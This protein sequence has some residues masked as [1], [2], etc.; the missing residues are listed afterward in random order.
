MKTID[1]GTL[2]VNPRLLP[3]QNMNSAT[4]VSMIISGLRTNDRGSLKSGKSPSEIA[5]E[6]SPLLMELSGEEKDHVK[7]SL[8]VSPLIHGTG[9]YVAKILE[10]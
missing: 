4:R 9:E 3:I 7:K 5:R 10:R 6:F 1:T 8:T 2:W